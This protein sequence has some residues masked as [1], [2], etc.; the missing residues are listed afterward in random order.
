[1]LIAPGCPHCG[2]VSEILSGLVKE[3]LVGKLEII[4]LAVHPEA[5]AE[6]GTRSV[7]WFKIGE[8]SFT[9]AHTEGEI[10]SWA[11]KAAQGE[12]WTAYY[13]G[14]LDNQQLK[15]TSES[16]KQNPDR[17]CPLV[18]SLDDKD[19][20]LVVKIGIGA[21]LEDFEG[22]ASLAECIPQ[23]TELTRS[24]DPATR[25]D[26]CHYLGLTGSKEILPVISILLD[27]EA[28]QVR[29]IAADVLDEF[30]EV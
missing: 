2:S 16:L 27:D 24:E 7:P 23:L 1:L 3:G 4:N 6:A 11:E 25:A 14:L 12:D 17:L 18:A 15:E 29:E 28:E 22:D 30:G 8:Y 20:P 5:A 21:V 26:A 13:H 9:G 19:L 10:R